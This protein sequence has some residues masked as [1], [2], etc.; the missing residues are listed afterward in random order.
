MGDKLV[1]RWTGLFKILQINQSGTLRL[2]GRKTQ[3]NTS[4]GKIYSGGNPEQIMNCRETSEEVEVTEED[5][6]Q[7]ISEIP[8]ENMT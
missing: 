8:A 3:V 4:L 6:P 1:P 7:I 5:N 2:E